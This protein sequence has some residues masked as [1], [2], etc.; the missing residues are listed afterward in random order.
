MVHLPSFWKNPKNKIPHMCELSPHY[1]D[2]NSSFFS[3]RKKKTD[4]IPMWRELPFNTSQARRGY[5]ASG[6]SIST[7]DRF[8]KI[9]SVL[10]LPQSL[11]KYCTYCIYILIIKTLFHIIP[12]GLTTCIAI[13]IDKN[14][15]M[16]LIL[17][18]IDYLSRQD[19]R[20]HTSITLW[21]FQVIYMT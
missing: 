11:L 3:S 17:Y 7:W 6:N 14:Y 8:I 10:P 13:V 16:Q 5:T 19:C 2:W 15:H 21:T 12:F 20:K 18:M 1:S 4:K 9:V